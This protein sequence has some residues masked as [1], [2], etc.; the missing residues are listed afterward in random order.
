MCAQPRPGAAQTRGKGG[1]GT[2]DAHTR[3]MTRGEDARSSGRWLETVATLS[4]GPQPRFHA[5]FTEMGE[6]PKVTSTTL[7]AI[8]PGI[9][10][11]LLVP[12]G[13][14]LVVLLCALTL[15]LAVRAHG[16]AATDRAGKMRLALESRQPVQVLAPN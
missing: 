6:D 1:R 2:R 14:L 12:L 10:T 11:L 7:A 5:G 15:V 13:V 4:P 3:R 8:D 9:S 16:S